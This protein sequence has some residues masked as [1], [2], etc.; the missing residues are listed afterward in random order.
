[1]EDIEYEAFSSSAQLMAEVVLTV[2]RRIF[3]GYYQGNYNLERIQ[4][5]VEFDIMRV[6]DETANGHTSLRSEVFFASM[7]F[8]FQDYYRELRRE[9]D[10]ESFFGKFCLPHGRYLI[11]FLHAMPSSD[12]ESINRGEIPNP[13][14]ED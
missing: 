2:T 11:V 3:E 14:A 5:D 1:M 10:Y 12:L 7:D 4:H 8:K 6:P 9:C 13:F